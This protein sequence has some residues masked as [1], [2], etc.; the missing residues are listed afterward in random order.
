MN[1]SFARRM[2][3]STAEGVGKPVTVT[4]PE[5]VAPPELPPV[6]VELLDVAAPPEPFTP[7]ELFT[8]PEPVVEPPVLAVEPPV[9]E[10]PAPPGELAEDELPFLPPV[11][12]FWFVESAHAASV[13]AADRRNARQQVI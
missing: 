9:R 6:A 11:P 1:Q 7:P 2:A 5:L 8:P 12:G 3:A 10:P 13:T 4:A